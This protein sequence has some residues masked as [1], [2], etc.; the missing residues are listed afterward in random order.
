MT[1]R[2]ELTSQELESVAG[3]V[4]H[5][6]YNS[7]GDYLC[8]VDGIGAFYAAEG[9]KRKINLHNIENPGMSDSDLVEWAKSE[10][11]LWN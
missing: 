9:A 6:Q 10:N 2:I 4:F 7:K 3:G 8:M 11:L 5:F 1:D